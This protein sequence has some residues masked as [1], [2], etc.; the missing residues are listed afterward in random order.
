[1]WQV[2]A[3]KVYIVSSLGWP[4]DVWWSRPHDPRRSRERIK[5]ERPDS[6]KLAILHRSSDLTPVWVPETTHEASHDL[7]RTRVDASMHPNACRPAVTGLSA[8]V[9]PQ[10]SEREALDAARSL[11]QENAF[12]SV[13]NGAL[14]EQL[15]FRATIT[16]ING[17][18]VHHGPSSA[19]V[20]RYAPVELVQRDMKLAATVGNDLRLHR[21]ADELH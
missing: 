6:E 11:S 20:V 17:H 16:R 1:M 4:T 5:I 7:V 13:G 14:R 9:W 15:R 19:V 21:R 18:S 12:L 3:A 10:L 2:A 8:S